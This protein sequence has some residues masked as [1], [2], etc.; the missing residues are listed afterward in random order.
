MIQKISAKAIKT[1]ARFA[2]DGIDLRPKET[3]IAIYEALAEALPQKVER[4]AARKLA[5][6]MRE[7]FQLQMEFDRLLTSSSHSPTSH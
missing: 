4:L 6:S 3:Q 1:L 7:A 2:M 5:F